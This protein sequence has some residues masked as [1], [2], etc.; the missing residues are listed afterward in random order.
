MTYFSNTGERGLIYIKENNYT[1]NMGK[2][3]ELIR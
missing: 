3:E 1:D 2:I